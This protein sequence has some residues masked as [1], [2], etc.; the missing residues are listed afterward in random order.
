MPQ[1][2]K[3]NLDGHEIELT[4]LDK[5]F[6]PDGTTKSDLIRYYLKIA[7]VMLPHLEGRPLSFQ[8]FPDG[9]DA[10]GFFQKQ[11]PRSY[12][13]WIKRISQ[14]QKEIVDYAS[15]D[16]AAD[17]VYFAQ[18]AVIVFHTALARGDKADYPDLMIFDLDPQTD[19]FE[20][21]RQTA[22]GLKELLDGLDLKSYLK[23]TGGR[24]LH[25]TV[26]LD[27]GDNFENVHGFAL[28]LARFYQTRHPDDTTTEMSKA[29]RGSRVFIDVN[30]N[31]F[32]QTAVAP[33]SV[34]ARKTPSIAAPI[35]WEELE[36]PDLKPDGYTIENIFKLLERRPD[37]WKNIY[38]NGQSIKGAAEKLKK[39]ES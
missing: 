34:R 2:I 15:A 37:P 27:R 38:K 11:A 10:E 20:P 32:S 39:L 18:Q 33:Y 24:G 9:V 16:S 7:T 12:P 19:S 17:L 35:T 14:G 8:R 3:T 29:K 36:S 31:H 28:R 25:V 26:P 6:F 5:V 1:K 13:D 22:F 21:V 30:R 23:V 4:N